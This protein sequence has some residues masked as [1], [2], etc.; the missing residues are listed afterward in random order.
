[1]AQLLE[2]R[3]EQ[4]GEPAQVLLVEDEVLIRSML[5]EEL[6][7]AGLRVIEAGNA[8]EAWDFLITGGRP[9]LVFSDVTMPG[10]IDGLEL[11]RRIKSAYP[12]VKII[13]TSGNPGPRNISEYG[14]FLPKPYQLDRA[15]AMTLASL[16]L[17]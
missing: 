15:A 2:A 16:G 9:D 6:R 1:V 10:S 14:F 12:A 11:T 13:I 3:L 7:A 17:R 4:G 8:D 5:A